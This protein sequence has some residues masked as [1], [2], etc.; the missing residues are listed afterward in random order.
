MTHHFLK[1][2]KMNFLEIVK[3][4][5]KYI[6]Q[7]VIDL[8]K[9]E[10]LLDEEN[11][12]EIAP[13]GPKVREALDFML[14]KAKADGFK[15]QDLNGY[16]G[17][18]SF[19]SQEEAIS[20]LGHLDVVPASGKWFTKSPFEPE[21]KDGYLIGRGTGDDKGPSVAAYYAMKILKDIG[22]QFEHRIDLILGCDEE[23]GMRCMTH[24]KEKVNHL[25]LKGLVPDADFPVVFAEKGILQF[26]WVF[27]NTSNIKKCQ[28][29][30]RPNIVIDYV[31]VE[32]NHQLDKE[33][34]QKSLKAMGFDCKIGDY[35]LEVYGKAYH[36]SLPQHGCNAALAALSVIAAHENDV[37][38][39]TISDAL[40]NPFGDGL[41]IQQDGQ[42]MGPLTLNCGVVDITE[43]EIV[44]TIDIRY[45]VE[46]QSQDILAAFDAIDG[47][48]LRHVSD[49]KPL[50]VDPQSD[51][52]QSALN[53]YRHVSNDTQTPALT[54]GGGT[55]AR[56]LPNHVAFGAGFP[57]EKKPEW[58]GGPHEINEAISLDSLLK[59]C[60]IYCE[61]LV[62]LA[63]GSR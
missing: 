35:H 48:T 60:A 1:G 12:T 14:N 7:D 56:T 11:K 63:K 51:L 24:Y 2:E 47:S 31:M 41:G 62:S 22:Y 53:A 39:S 40:R 44:L 46:C 57:L 58:V 33:A 6:L 43:E 3:K 52:V 21:M 18:I 19:G 36:A 20:M 29:G 45:P 25:P 15:T 26:Q 4:Y 49:S 8:V 42:S 55:Y 13:F 59:A 27:K 23:T 38:L 10:S 37:L 16:A 50:Y 9:I 34:Y 61:A 30:S 54:M 28:A 17:I 5:E 32:M